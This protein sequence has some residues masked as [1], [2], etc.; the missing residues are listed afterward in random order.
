MHLLHLLLSVSSQLGRGGYG[1]VWLAR[2]RR[3]AAA[4]SSATPFVVLKKI[5]VADITAADSYQ[6]EARRLAHLMHKF[7]VR[8]LL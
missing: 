1:T 3:R 2:L 4:E 7:V 6:Q 5:A 8:K